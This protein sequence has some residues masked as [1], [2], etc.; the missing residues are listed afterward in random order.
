MAVCSLKVNGQGCAFGNLG[1]RAQQTEL[2]KQGGG[3]ETR[4]GGGG[5]KGLQSGGV[6]FCKENSNILERGGMTGRRRTPASEVTGLWLQSA[7]LMDQFLIADLSGQQELLRG[8][9]VIIWCLIMLQ[10][11]FI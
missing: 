6:N 7:S 8:L 1:R 10:L 5:A 4:G 11:Q 9:A 2:Q 3:A